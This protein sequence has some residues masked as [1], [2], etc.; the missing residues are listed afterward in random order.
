MRTKY[1]LYM[2]FTF[3]DISGNSKHFG[4]FLKWLSPLYP[5]DS[6]N[7]VVMG[8]DVINAKNNNKNVNE[9]VYSKK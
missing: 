3:Y 9:R 1:A 7:D 2:H 6:T 8:I 5:P 4:S